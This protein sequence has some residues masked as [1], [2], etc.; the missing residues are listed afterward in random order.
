MVLRYDQMSLYLWQP[1]HRLGAVQRDLETL[2]TEGLVAGEI[3]ALRKLGYHKCFGLGGEE[4]LVGLAAS[5]VSRTLN[6]LAEPRALLSQHCRA[7]CAALPPEANDTVGAT[8]NRYLP[9]AVLRELKLDHV[10]YF[11]SFASGCAG[12]ISLLALAGGVFLSPNDGAV[13]CF[14]ADCKPTG[15][16]FD[17]VRERILGSDHASAFLVGREP[18]GYQLLGINFYSTPRVLVPLVEI[19]KRTVRMTQELAACTGVNLAESDVGIHFPNI[20]PDTWKMVARYLRLGRGETIIDE[21]AERAHC[22][23]TDSVITLAKQ[24]RGS[25]GRIHLVVNYGAGLHLGV[26][27]LREHEIR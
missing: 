2:K 23:A 10:P 20:F 3:E 6:G 15:V 26:A 21:M 16:P 7:E 4:T 14:M 5:T 25:A 19:V 24:H 27:L 12:F 9:A 22:G 13:L 11:C 18:R 1:N 17:M 8:R